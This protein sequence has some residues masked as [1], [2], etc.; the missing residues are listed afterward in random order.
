MT[1]GAT[2][3]KAHFSQGLQRAC[4]WA[5]YLLLP[6]LEGLSQVGSIDEMLNWQIGVCVCTC[7]LRVRGCVYVSNCACT[8]SRLLTLDPVGIASFERLSAQFILSQDSERASPLVT[9]SASAL[10]ANPC[11]ATLS[12]FL[13]CSCHVAFSISFSCRTPRKQTAFPSQSSKRLRNKL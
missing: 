13:A 2:G 1:C 12:P 10:E 8:S 7:T 3:S 6:A 11:W 4:L 9:S 5:R